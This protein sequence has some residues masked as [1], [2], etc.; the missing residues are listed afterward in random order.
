M[1]RI[2]QVRVEARRLRNDSYAERDKNFKI[3]LRE[4]NKRVEESGIKQLL[5]DKQ[6]F[7]SKGEKARRK[8]KDMIRKH[9]QQ[10]IVDA[11]ER[12][13]SPK[14]ALQFRGKKKKKNNKSDKSSD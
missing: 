9:Q 6:Y 3:L 5:K 1:A 12:G 2:A 11:I 4:F 10:M 7:E 13:E 14:G 8:R